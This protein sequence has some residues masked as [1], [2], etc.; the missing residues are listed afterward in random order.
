MNI[1]EQHI[2]GISKQQTKQLELLEKQLLEWNKK[3]NLVSRKDEQNIMEHHI[4]HSLSI[5][6]FFSFKPG[7]SLLDVGTGGGLPGLPL[8]ILFPN[9]QFHLIDATGKKITAV[10]NMI[11]DLNLENVTAE[12]TRLE[13]HKKKY[14]FILS[15]AVANLSRFWGWMPK[16]ILDNMHNN[17][18]PNGI[19]YL[20]GGEVSEEIRQVPLKATIYHLSRFSENSYFRTKKI[21][22]LYT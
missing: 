6:A 11:E 3:V 13:N 9:C 19:I 8:A 17:S 7:T 10:K 15:R 18:F 21:I 12:Q 4:L 2:P 20:K 22:H 5:A 16:N 14:H 1:L